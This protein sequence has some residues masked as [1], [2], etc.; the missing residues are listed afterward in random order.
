MKKA[1]T[2][3][4]LI[5]VVLAVQPF[6]SEAGTYFLGAKGWYTS[7]DSGI[8]DWLE[9]DIA[10]SF[11]QNRVQ[12]TATSDPGSGY[13]AGPLL[14]Y[15]TD[16][17]KWSMSA[18]LMVFSNFKQDWSGTAAGMTLGGSADLKRNDYDF[19][20]NYSLSKH[21]TLF[22]GYKFQDMS[23]DFNLTFGTVLGTQTD[24]FEVKATAHIP[25]FGAGVV[26]PLH[27][28]VVV[29]GQAGLLFPMMTMEVTNANGSTEDVLPHGE[30][31][32]NAEGNLT[33]LPLERLIL[34]VGYR[35]QMFE[36]KARGPGR[37]TISDSRDITHGPTLSVVYTF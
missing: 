26:Y 10:L 36:F 2:F 14:G 34:Q 6:P 7:W 22:A 29:S 11:Q 21:F 20:V 32:F 12:F 17:G 37:T 28:K 16:D 25:S 13:L 31:G 4:C 24:K 23:L 19:V 35:Y 1:L 3:C 27:E 5:A 9:K 15:Q 33:W 18:A 30:L 8:L